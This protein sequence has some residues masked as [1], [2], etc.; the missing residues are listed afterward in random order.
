V[1]GWELIS[2]ADFDR[3]GIPDLVWQNT[4][5]RQIGVWYMSGT[6]TPA[7][8][9]SAY[10]APGTYAGWKLVSVADVDCNGT[11]DLIW[12]HDITRSVAI[13][14]MSGPQGTDVLGSTY[15]APGNYSGWTLVGVADLD[16]NGVPD[17]L[18]QNDSTRSVGVWFMSGSRSNL[19]ASGSEM[20][21]GGPYPNWRV[22]AVVDMNGD[23][24]PDLIWQNDVTR[25]VVVW[26]LGGSRGTTV[27]N[28]AV[29]V[30]DGYA[31][32]R[33]LGPK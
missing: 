13:W 2:I 32:W 27:A 33:A 3:N 29:I 1:P 23:G 5:T 4:A 18:W 11:P 24:A 26:Y 14:F 19:V 17:L 25:G 28:T 6:Q 31:G 20:F 8:V 30:A 22:V 9:G 15:A 10:P 21:G 7:V 12:Q 16:H